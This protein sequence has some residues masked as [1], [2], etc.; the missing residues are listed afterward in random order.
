MKTGQ[1]L[2]QVEIDTINNL[3]IRNITFN[4]IATRRTL[5]FEQAQDYVTTMI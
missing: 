4:T 1:T 2:P 5:L 3:P